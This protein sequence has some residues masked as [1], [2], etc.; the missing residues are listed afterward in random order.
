MK[1]NNWK[2]K[3]HSLTPIRDGFGATKFIYLSSSIFVRRD[4]IFSGLYINLIHFSFCLQNEGRGS[5]QR[6]TLCAEEEG[7]S[8]R[9]C[10]EMGLFEQ[11]FE[12]IEECN[13][14]NKT[15]C[16]R[17]AKSAPN[18]MIIQGLPKLFISGHVQLWNSGYKGLLN[19]P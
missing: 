4:W 5:R 3:W 18:V 17:W 8:V 10:K 13:T 19:E 15:T 2:I 7:G 14:W 6:F 1:F 12:H 11:A 16:P 9:N